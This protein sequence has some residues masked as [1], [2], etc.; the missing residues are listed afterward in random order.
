MR[1]V[2][3]AAIMGT[4]D[5][6]SLLPGAIAHLRRIGVERIVVIDWGSTDGTLE[7]LAQEEQ[8][9]DL[10]TVQ[11]PRTDDDAPWQSIDGILARALSA[12]WVLFL[13]T[14][15]RWVPIGGHLDR[16]E[17]LDDL[18][19]IRVQRFNAVILPDGPA[20]PDPIDAASLDRLLLYALG[21]P[22]A[23]RLI[24]NDPS[25][26]WV[27]A[28]QDPKVMVR[29]EAIASMA[30]GDHDVTETPGRTWRRAM[31]PDC[32]IVHLPFTTLEQFE[33]KVANIRIA[34][35]T[36]PEYFTGD[37][38]WQWTHWVQLDDAGQTPEEF[39][40]QTIDHDRLAELRTRGIIR[41]AA[42]L[43]EP[44]VPEFADI[45]AYNAAL[46]ELDP[47]RPALDAVLRAER[48]RPAG[49][50]VLPPGEPGQQP[51]VLMP[52][53]LAVKIYGPWNIGLETW[54]A[55]EQ[56]Y[57]LAKADR[58]MPVP[59]I[60]GSGRLAPD[61]RYLVTEMLSGQPLVEVRS[62]L[63]ERGWRGVAGWLGRVM[64]QL[65]DVPLPADVR[66]EG[67]AMFRGMLE[68]HR[69]GATGFYRK[70]TSL[71]DHLID[72]I[73]GW[74]PSMEELLEDL[75]TPVLIHGDVHDA[76]VLGI[77][78]DGQFKAT[79]ILDLGR[80]MIGHPL[81]E[82][83]PVSGFTFHGDRELIA[84]WARWAAPPGFGRPGFARLALAFTLLH[85]GDTL[86]GLPQLAEARDLDALADA[87][88]GAAEAAGLAGRSAG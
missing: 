17:G 66:D 69:I 56:A 33:T 53:D 76:N 41:S 1:H 38:G 51:V 70:R 14:D 8:R 39:A 27:Q 37:Q 44:V 47:W 46:R 82:I 49:S 75:V 35:E 31:A 2:R 32:L 10:W 25:L 58:T 19:I 85:R 68:W 87:L 5:E 60:L 65:W 72:Q 54:A 52:P 86:A 21:V 3:F 81:F 30:N 74:L 34:I 62:Q 45:E 24:P 88:Y 16:M 83:G 12:D 61:W 78:S 4:L 6:A 73:E 63:D 80:A 28:W 40:R 20:V 7:I 26:P 15:E 29:P 50:W 77:P 71:P 67:W 13:D 11:A 79:G 43:L 57:R 84:E 59:R 9:G 42:D 36:S 22:D 64:R 23:H 18:D 48:L 55:E